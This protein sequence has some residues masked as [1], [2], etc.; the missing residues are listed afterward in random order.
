MACVATGEENPGDPRSGRNAAN[1][2]SASPSPTSVSRQ[3]PCSPAQPRQAIE[4]LLAEARR[5]SR[6]EMTSPVQV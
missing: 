2:A 4:S 3:L 1:L 6:C 5:H